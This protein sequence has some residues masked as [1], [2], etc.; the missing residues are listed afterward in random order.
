MALCRL[1]TIKGRVQGV[2]FRDS[3][4]R[5]AQTL[6][7]TGYAINLSDGDV[8]VLACGDRDSIDELAVWL[9][10]GPQMARVNDVIARDIEVDAPD[11]F[12]TG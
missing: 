10:N 6:G 8:E 2:F 9:Q 7:I 11:D 5:V 1:F 4:R 3:T 12:Q